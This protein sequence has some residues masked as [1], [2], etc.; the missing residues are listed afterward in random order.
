[1]RTRSRILSDKT[2]S[3]ELVQPS[4]RFI[5]QSYS[6]PGWSWPAF[7]SNWRLDTGVKCMRIMEDTVTER[8]RTRQASGELIM[9]PMRS[10]EIHSL[11]PG[12]HD[13]FN[14]SCGEL[15][16]DGTYPYHIN[17]AHSG[18][19]VEYGFGTKLLGSYGIHSED[20]LKQTVGYLLQ[21]TAARDRMAN[22]QTAAISSAEARA[23]TGCANVL[24]TLAESRE[25]YRLLPDMCR[26]LGR[27]LASTPYSLFVRKNG[28]LVVDSTSNAWLQYRY[29]VRPLLFDIRDYMA[30]A[31][32]RIHSRIYSRSRVSKE[33]CSSTEVFLT[34]N[35]DCF[36]AS[37]VKHTL[38]NLQTYSVRAGVTSDIDLLVANLSE[39]RYRLDQILSTAWELVPFSFI[40]DWFL[41]IG[42]IL[43]NL[44]PPDY[45]V[46]QAGF[47][48]ATANIIVSGT[49]ELDDP[50]A[51]H[52]VASYPNRNVKY[53]LENYE[54]AAP[55]F[56]VS[57]TVKER[58][59]FQPGIPSLYL[60]TKRW[61]TLPHLMDLLALLPQIRI[62]R[63]AVKWL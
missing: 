59:L 25:T 42:D 57:V 31:E 56:N 51:T 49:S 39:Q 1:M 52:M 23:S 43:A 9:N 19:M 10:I 54:L 29:G 58:S 13:T 6:G 30:A 53:V 36:P 33:E 47:V 40:I 16:S 7:T 55:G 14:A 27:I 20:D 34:G 26:T 24:L 22:L 18:C 38:S 32:K 44:T 62:L 48:T 50:N 11:N 37:V 8:F 2:S 15:G 45:L 28:Q 60:D 35:R 63:K 5:A 21:K 3:V 46:K 4:D 41:N 12:F 61:R 17:S